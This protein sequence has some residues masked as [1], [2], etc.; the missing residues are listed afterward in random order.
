MIITT[1]EKSCETNRAWLGAFLS[2]ETPGRESTTS[3]ITV[4]HR[5]HGQHEA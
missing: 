4:S 5:V 1:F 2:R 3:D